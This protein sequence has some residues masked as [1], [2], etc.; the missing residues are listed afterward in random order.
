MRSG[1]SLSTTLG[2][3]PGDANR[4]HRASRA[5]NPWSTPALPMWPRPGKEVDFEW[6][7]DIGE[8]HP[9]T[10]GQLA[11]KWSSKQPEAAQTSI[12]RQDVQFRFTTSE[13]WSAATARAPGGREGTEDRGIDEAD[14]TRLST[15][16]GGI[17]EVDEKR[18][19]Y[20]PGW[21]YSGVVF[22]DVP[23]SVRCQGS[24]TGFPPN[25][26]SS[27]QVVRVRSGEPTHIAHKDPMCGPMLAP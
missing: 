6:T 9:A 26:C 1:V 14:V 24:R 4:K 18:A 20:M 8:R 25:V 23:R 15:R 5:G 21:G 22:H 12:G 2:T 19:G 7:A 13:R 10:F 17:H 16:R 3:V 11:D 27:A